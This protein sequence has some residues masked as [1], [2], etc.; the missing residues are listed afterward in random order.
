MSE[1]WRSFTFV[2]LVM[3][4][5]GKMCA[6]AEDSL[7]DMIDRAHSE[8]N[9]SAALRSAR[10]RL[11]VA[12]CKGNG[13]VFRRAVGIMAKVT[14]QDWQRGAPTPFLDDASDE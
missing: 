13:V 3:E 9:C 6:Q 8:A 10:V 1:E 12:L 4:T 14:G 2:P 11:R 5:Y 7:R